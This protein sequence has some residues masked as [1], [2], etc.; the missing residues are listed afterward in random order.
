MMTVTDVMAVLAVFTFGIL[1]ACSGPT[2]P[3]RVGSAVAVVAALLAWGSAWTWVPPIANWR[4]GPSVSG[5]P[6]AVPTLGLIVSAIL[7]LSLIAVSSPAQR[8]VFAA[9]DRR[10]AL[11]LGSWRTVFGVSLMMIGLAGGLPPGFFWSAGIG[12]ILVG[13]VSTALLGRGAHVSDRAWVGWNLLG[14]LD[15]LHVVALAA[16]TVPPFVAANPTLPVLNLVPLLVVPSF[17]AL[18]VGAL[19]HSFRRQKRTSAYVSEI[20]T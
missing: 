11:A 9:M 14:L 6:S 2:S 4:L 12:D 8:R 5:G 20:L 1:L 13:V 18:H 3:Q 16:L 17:I 15:L 19:R 7:L 10:A